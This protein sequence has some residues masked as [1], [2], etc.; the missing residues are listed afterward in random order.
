MDKASVAIRVDASTRI[1]SGH[2][3]RCLT[4]A[5]ALRDRNLSCHFLCRDLAGHMSGVIAE[6]GFDVT[7]LSTPLTEKRDSWL[8][9]DWQFDALQ[10]A[11]VLEEIAPRWL[12]VDHYGL[13]VRWEKLAGANIVIV[14][15]DDLADRPHAAAL[16]VDPTH[17]RRDIEYSSLVSGDCELLIGARHAIL[18]NAF[19]SLREAAIQS[20]TSERRERLLITMG[21]YDADNATGRVLEFVTGWR[22]LPFS[23]VDVVLG[24]QAPWLQAVRSQI[25]SLPVP[26][27]LHVDTSDM[28]QLML[29]ADL[30]IGA[31]GTSAW[32]RCVIGL[33]TVL[34]V[35]AE[36]QS[37]VARSLAEAGAAILVGGLG[38]D[39]M[40]RLAA[41][42]ADALKPGRLRLMAQSASAVTDGNG[43]IRVVNSILASQLGARPA[44]MDDAIDIWHWR[45]D[46]NAA[47]YYRQTRVPTLEQHMAWFEQALADP[48]RLMIVVDDEGQPIGH[49]RFDLSQD[50]E[51]EVSICLAPGARG[52]RLAYPVLRAALSLARRR[53]IR[54]VTAAVHREN[55]SSLALFRHC[56]FILMSETGM[57]KTFALELLPNGS[58]L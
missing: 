51:A 29:A 44:T 46:G 30:C 1:G 35:L 31:A 14:A 43:T 12:V 34:V 45:F 16:L 32:E 28:P 52:K 50:S 8:G 37:R 19:C 24:G 11:P 7:L 5:D 38:T 2:V 36:N 49:V 17:G 20:R 39:F 47:Q 33:P 3:M 27:Q 54:R 25:A 22:D 9:V 10:C 4:L 40:D 18:R 42:L 48:Q 57:F 15:I 13:D 41:G 56:D 26:S 23:S 6:R 58:T 53:G 55:L 21:G